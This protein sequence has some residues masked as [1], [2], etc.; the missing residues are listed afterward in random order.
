M[1]PFSVSFQLLCHFWIQDPLYFS[2]LREGYNSVL[3][4]SSTNV[5]WSMETFLFWVNFSF[6]L[7]SVCINAATSEHQLYL[8]NLLPTQYPELQD[9]ATLTVMEVILLRGWDL[10]T[11]PPTGHWQ[12]YSGESRV[13]TGTC[14]NPGTICSLTYIWFPTAAWSAHCVP[15]CVCVRVWMR[16]MWMLQVFKCGW[17]YKTKSMPCSCHICKYTLLQTHF[18]ASACLCMQASGRS[19][20]K[21]AWIPLQHFLSSH[22]TLA[23]PHCVWPLDHTRNRLCGSAYCRQHC[24]TTL[25]SFISVISRAR[26]RFYMHQ[27]EVILSS[28]H[29]LDYVLAAITGVK[30]HQNPGRS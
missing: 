20:S 15:V 9:V 28:I 5:L 30:T 3:L 25:L 27:I 21:L 24:S 18:N 17:G 23:V 7:C 11:S 2:C 1:E 26:Q 4:W 13:Q 14:R 12:F 10:N 29:S 6:K 22:S 16:L 8:T 19:S